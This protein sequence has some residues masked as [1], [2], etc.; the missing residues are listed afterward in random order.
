MRVGFGG[1]PDQV[2][3]VG[4]YAPRP[5]DRVMKILV[6]AG[7]SQQAL[8]PERAVARLGVSFPRGEPHLVLGRGGDR[9][10]L[11]DFRCQALQLGAAYIAVISG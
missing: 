5:A 4:P 10:F 6:V 2:V 9:G 7:W 11:Y 1:E 8:V 3:G